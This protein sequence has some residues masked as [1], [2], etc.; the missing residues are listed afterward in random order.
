MTHPTVQSYVDQLKK[1]KEDLNKEVARLAKESDSQEYSH[2]YWKKESEELEKKNKKLNA[3]IDTLKDEI[4]R[5]KRKILPSW[6]NNSGPKATSDL[7]SQLKY[8]NET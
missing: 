4:T 8:L 5:L 3:E 6:I 1:D 7:I 2:H